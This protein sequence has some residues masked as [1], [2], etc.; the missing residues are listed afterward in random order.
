MKKTWHSRVN[1]A[2]SLRAIPEHLNAP[3]PDVRQMLADEH[4]GQMSLM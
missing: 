3:K 1:Q 2:L 4:V